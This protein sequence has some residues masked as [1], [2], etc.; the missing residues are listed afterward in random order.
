MSVD[1]KNIQKTQFYG[2]IRQ[3]HQE[4]AQKPKKLL[5][6]ISN[7]VRITKIPTERMKQ[8]SCDGVNVGKS[9]NILIYKGSIDFA[10]LLQ[11]NLPLS[12][13]SSRCV[14]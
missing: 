11:K 12:L 10:T 8:P 3:L 13:Q 14:K 1:H 6:I 9:N 4:Y 7:K 2:R 5:T